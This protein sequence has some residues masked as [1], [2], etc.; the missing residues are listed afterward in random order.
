[1][2]RNYI[3]DLANNAKKYKHNMKTNEFYLTKNQYNILYAW[4]M[5]SIALTKSE[6]LIL[7]ESDVEFNVE[8]EGDEVYAV[9]SYSESTCAFM[10]NKCP[11]KFIQNGLSDIYNVPFNKLKQVKYDKR[12]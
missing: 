4:I 1:M 8:A 2:Q 11:F 10:I 3:T 9:I 5:T 12:K 6:K 7:E